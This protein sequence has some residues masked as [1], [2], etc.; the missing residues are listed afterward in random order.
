[1]GQGFGC[2]GEWSG[3]RVGQGEDGCGGVWGVRLGVEWSGVERG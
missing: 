3:D 2:G 1:M